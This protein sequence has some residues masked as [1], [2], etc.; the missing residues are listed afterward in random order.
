MFSETKIGD[1]FRGGRGGLLLLDV[2]RAVEP[3]LREFLGDLG[4]GFQRH[5]LR[6]ALVGRAGQTADGD[7]AWFQPNSARIQP[8]FSP[9]FLGQLFYV[10]YPPVMSRLGQDT[11]T[12][13]NVREK[14]K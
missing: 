2:V 1:F 4:H 7:R 12:S 3:L 10:F 14:E 9:V 5:N 6:L 8:E 11:S 13:E